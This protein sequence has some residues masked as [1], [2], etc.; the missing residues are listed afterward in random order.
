M[1]KRV[2][3]ATITGLSFQLISQLLANLGLMLNL[4]PPLMV[5]IPVVAILFIGAVSMRRAI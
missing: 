4:S 2:V 1:G 3:L 5:L